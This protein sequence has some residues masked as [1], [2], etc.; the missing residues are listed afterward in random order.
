MSA[1]MQALREQIERHTATTRD[2]AA[3]V[4]HLADYIDTQIV[5]LV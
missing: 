5:G 4:M 3:E 1:S 2:L